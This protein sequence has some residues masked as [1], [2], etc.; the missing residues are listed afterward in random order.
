MDRDSA[1]KMIRQHVSLWNNRIL[2]AVEA[3]VSL[4]RAELS[5]LDL[6]GIDFRGVDLRGAVLSGSDLRNALLDAANLSHAN[7]EGADLRAASLK[8]VVLENA[9]LSRCDC[10]SANFTEAD[11]RIAMLRN[12]VFLSANLSRCDLTNANID[13]TSFERCNLSNARLSEVGYWRDQEHD[14]RARPPN[15]TRAI[16]N[17]ATLRKLDLRGAM[18]IHANLDNASLSDVVLS[19]CHC[20]GT[21]WGQAWLSRV[22]LRSAVLIGANFTDA[23][24][25]DCTL[26]EITVDQATNLRDVKTIEGTSVDR[27]TL[28]TMIG[29]DVMKPGQRMVMDVYDDVAKLRLLFSGF[30][31]WAHLGALALFVLPYAWFLAVNHWRAQLTPAGEGQTEILLLALVRYILSGKSTA[32]PLWEVNIL[33]FGLFL[34]AFFF[35]AIRL[36]LLWKTNELEHKEQVTTIPQKWSLRD[37]RYWNFAF[38]SAKLFLRLFILIAIVRFALFLWEPVPVR[39]APDTPTA[40]DTR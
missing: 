11:L 28:E 25:R 36:H 13:G 2:D 20:S 14:D 22:S 26:H 37:N 10:T 24:V 3:S 34:L 7:L 38:R 27:F 39:T 31:R 8:G 21:S 23:T 4:A 19:E 33:P 35:N 30:Y 40:L 16:L 29:Q 6:R 9:N 18:F 17:H 5:D 15:F 1:I 32:G 12:T